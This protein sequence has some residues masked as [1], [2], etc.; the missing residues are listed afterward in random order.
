MRVKVQKCTESDT[1]TGD[2]TWP[3]FF[4]QLTFDPVTQ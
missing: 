1:M 4:D 3:T 2:S